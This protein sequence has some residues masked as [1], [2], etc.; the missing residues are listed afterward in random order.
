VLWHEREDGM[1]DFRARLPKEEA[2]VLL[3]A[4]EAAKDQFGTPPP[5]KPDPCGDASQQPGAGPGVGCIAMRMRWWMWPVASWTPC[6]RTAPGK[7]APSSSYRC[8]Q[9]T[10]PER[11]QTFQLLG[12]GLLIAL[13]AKPGR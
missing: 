8:R 4:I 1:I 10:W 9:K 6:L 13:V 7:A 12:V 2:A 5:P 11:L 3:A